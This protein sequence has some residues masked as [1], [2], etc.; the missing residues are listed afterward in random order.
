MTIEIVDPTRLKDSLSC[1]RLYFWRHERHVIPVKPRLPLIYGNAVH[2]C[3]AAHYEGK[4]G[5]VAFGAFEDT[6]TA[7]LAQD[8]GPVAE[9]ELFQEDEDP[10]R[11]PTRWL[12]QWVLYRKQ[13]AVEP[14]SVRNV[15][16]PFFLPLTDDLALAGII[17]L[18]VEYL[19]QI[20]I[21]DH[22]TTSY[23]N[24]RWIATFNP[25][26]QFSAYLLA[27]NELIKPDRPITTLLVNAIL[28]HKT[29]SNPDKLFARIPTTRSTAQLEEERDELVGWWR[30]VRECRRTGSWPKNDQRCQDYQGC[31]YHPLCT[32]IQANFRRLI[33]SPALFKEEAW[34]PIRSLRRH[35][36]D[37]PEGVV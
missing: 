5:A 27:A 31:D 20:M 23:L 8:G 6:W 1:L 22:K 32:D 37:L 14:F 3:L 35:G 24:H 7:A 13:Y 30:I 18:V 26:H 11:N 2:A 10:K 9:P 34:D 33:P 17:D 16:V 25:N 29:E 19:G 36:A 4:S 28:S 12:E 21:V 15:E